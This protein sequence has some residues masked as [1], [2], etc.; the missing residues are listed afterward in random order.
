MKTKIQTFLE[1]HNSEEL[2]KMLSWTGQEIAEEL[3][4]EAELGL[5]ELWDEQVEEWEEEA[6]RC[7]QEFVEY[8]ANKRFFAVNY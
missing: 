6:L 3:E 7:E 4:I 5:K 1:G 2:H 8:E